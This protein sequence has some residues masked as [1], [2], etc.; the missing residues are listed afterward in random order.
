MA[1]ISVFS[2]VEDLVRRV[3]VGLTASDFEHDRWSFIKHDDGTQYLFRC[4][5]IR[6]YRFDRDTNIIYNDLAG[7]FI[8]VFTE[9]HRFHVFHVEDLEAWY[10]FKEFHDG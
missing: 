7:E 1:S 4:S 8:A 2:K 6:R 5:F 3:D 9:H 10:Q